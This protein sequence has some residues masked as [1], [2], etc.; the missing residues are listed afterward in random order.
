VLEAGKGEVVAEED[1]PHL[2]TMCKH[3]DMEEEDRDSRNMEPSRNVHRQGTADETR[4]SPKCVQG[5]QQ[6]ECMFLVRF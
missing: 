1:A 6:L 2:Q 5:T 3:W 4:Q